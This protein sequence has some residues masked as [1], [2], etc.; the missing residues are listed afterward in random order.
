MLFLS[1]CLRA[2]DDGLVHD[3]MAFKRPHP[4]PFYPHSMGWQ[5]NFPRRFLSKHKEYFQKFRDFLVESNEVGI[6]S[7]Q[8]TV[9]M[10]PGLFLAEFIRPHHRVL[11]MCAAPGNKTAQILENLDYDF[12]GKWKEGQHGGFVFAND[13]DG[14]RAHVMVHQLKRVGI[15]RFVAT[16]K[17][18]QCIPRMVG[19]EGNVYFDCI[20]CDV[21]CSSDGTLRKSPDLWKKWKIQFGNSLH[22]VQLSILIHAMHLLAAGGTIV[23]STCT[24]NPVEN[25]AVISSALLF[26]NQFYANTQDTKGISTLLCSLRHDAMH[27]HGGKCRKLQDFQDFQ[28]LKA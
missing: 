8:E 22:S 5:C 16:N 20:L 26:V 13:S 10:I 3:G 24:F 28:C 6:I 19:D 25:E 4:I 27:E 9:S 21:P 7:R 11:D 23:Y 15:N 2:E 17:L 12:S 18:A 1:L 14:K